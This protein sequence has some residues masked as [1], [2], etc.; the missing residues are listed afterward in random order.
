M[1]VS[2]QG[3]SRSFGEVVAVK[4]IDFEVGR[5]SDIYTFITM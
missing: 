4:G 5:M 1:T 3:L 2:V